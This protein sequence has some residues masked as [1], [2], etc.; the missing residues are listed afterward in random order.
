MAVKIDLGS[1][2]YEP[3][4]GVESCGSGIGA[5]PPTDQ[6]IPAITRLAEA[7]ERQAQ[8]IDTLAHVIASQYVEEGEQPETGVYLD[9]TPISGN[10]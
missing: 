6:L 10:G 9:G 3:H 4:D 5:V 2:V 8:A 7:I 1:R